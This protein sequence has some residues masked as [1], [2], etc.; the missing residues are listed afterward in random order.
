[1]TGTLTMPGP[2]VKMCQN[3]DCGGVGCDQIRRTRR[4][5]AIREHIRPDLGPADVLAFFR[6]EIAISGPKDSQGIAHMVPGGCEFTV[7]KGWGDIPAAEREDGRECYIAWYSGPDLDLDGILA[8]SPEW[9]HDLMLARLQAMN[10]AATA[11]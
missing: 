11:N 4:T 9:S 2:V 5:M 10:A 3:P 6:Q 8:G 7:H 1:M